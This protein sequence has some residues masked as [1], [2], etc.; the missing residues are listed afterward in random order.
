M[1]T[2]G[3]AIT[4]PAHELPTLDELLFP[5]WVALALQ[6]DIFSWEKERDAAK[7]CSQPDVVNAVWVLMGEHSINE[8]NALKLCR[9]RTKDFVAE[10]VSIFESNK[11]NMSLSVDLRTFM[12]AILYTLSGNAVWSITCPRYHPPNCYN[13]HQSLM[14]DV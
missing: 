8:K 6:N 3:M 11:D 10:Y 5:A 12:E 7:A 14:K 1:V 13:D 9:E 2:F 4:I